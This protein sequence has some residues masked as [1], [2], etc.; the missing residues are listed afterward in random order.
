MI[1]QSLQAEARALRRRR[2]VC[3]DAEAPGNRDKRREEGIALQSN[4]SHIW[5]VPK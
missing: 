2:A 1:E 5:R 3:L 4:G